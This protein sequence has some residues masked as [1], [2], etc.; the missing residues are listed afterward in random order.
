V[1]TFCKLSRLNVLCILSFVFLLIPIVSSHSESYD[2]YFNGVLSNSTV[3]GSGGAYRAAT[4]S[5]SMVELNPVAL[6]EMPS[7]Y[8]LSFAYGSI[9]QSYQKLS[10]ELGS[11]QKDIAYVSI[12]AGFRK[13]KWNNF[14]FG[15][16]LHHQVLI[17]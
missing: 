6:S 13:E 4:D 1:V 5:I 14:G 15:I 3:I 12:G 16:F 11:Q 10:P 9:E 17:N 2:A 7:W 8:S